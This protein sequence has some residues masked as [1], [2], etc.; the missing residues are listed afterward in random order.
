MSNMMHF[1]HWTSAAD[2]TKLVRLSLLLDRLP[3][4][5]SPSPVWIDIHSGLQ[6]ESHLVGVL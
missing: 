2:L 1:G 5:F 4:F 3:F 6:Q